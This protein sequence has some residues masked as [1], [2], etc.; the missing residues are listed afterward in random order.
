MA[1]V[2]KWDVVLVDSAPGRDV[3]VEHCPMCRQYRKV[4]VGSDG[5]TEYINNIWEWEAP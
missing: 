4:V 3:Y 5:R 2:H 1:C